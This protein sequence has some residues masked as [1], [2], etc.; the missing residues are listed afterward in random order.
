MRILFIF[1]IMEKQDKLEWAYGYY[2]DNDKVKA[3]KDF[4]KVVS[5]D[6]LADTFNK[7]ESRNNYEK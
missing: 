4:Q 6:N 7:K 1:L 3:Q 2:Y 5:G